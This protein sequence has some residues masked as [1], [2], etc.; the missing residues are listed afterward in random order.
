MAASSFLFFSFLVLFS[1][2]FFSA[3]STSPSVHYR[4]VSLLYLSNCS[5]CIVFTTSNNIINTAALNSYNCS[6]ERKEAPP[7]P[8]IS[9]IEVKK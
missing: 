2:L 6:L 9:Q 3:L 5:P 8:V 7:L 4:F 1:H